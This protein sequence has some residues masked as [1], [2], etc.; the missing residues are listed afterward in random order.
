[1]YSVSLHTGKRQQ[2]LLDGRA[3]NGEDEREQRQVDTKRIASPGPPPW[4]RTLSSASQPQKEAVLKPRTCVGIQKHRG[5]PRAPVWSS[6]RRQP[7]RGPCDNLSHRRDKQLRPRA[8]A[9]ERGV[10]VCEGGGPRKIHLIPGPTVFQTRSDWILLSWQNS[11]KWFWVF[12][13]T[14]KVFPTTR[15]KYG[16]EDYTNLHENKVAKLSLWLFMILL[17][18][19]YLFTDF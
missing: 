9:R 19:C 18:Y 7:P 17:I 8:P 15:Q 10:C 11:T 12:P 14:R 4:T 13:T 16:L 1:M 3:R 2:P 6:R 5:G